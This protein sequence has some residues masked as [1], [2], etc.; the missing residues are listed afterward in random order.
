MRQNKLFFNLLFIYIK[1]YFKPKTFHLV[2]YMPRFFKQKMI[3][4]K[5][6]DIRNEKANNPENREV[7]VYLM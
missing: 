7:Y 3:T 4:N 5:D 1:W 2:I 6:I